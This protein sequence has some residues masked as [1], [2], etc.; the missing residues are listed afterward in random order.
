VNTDAPRRAAGPA[1]IGH[2]LGFVLAIDGCTR[3]CQHCPAFGSTGPALR[4]GLDTLT[5]RLESIAR[6]RRA[7][8]LPA[9]PTRTVHCWRISDPLDYWSRTRR[10]GVATAA[11]VA[12]LWRDHLHQALYV[13]T[14]GS[15]GHPAGR[16]ALATFA[17]TPVLVS[18]LKITIT[19]ADLDWGTSRYVAEL[20]E[21][22]RLLL[23]LWELPADR[24]EA[25][26]NAARLRLNVKTTADKL[27]EAHEITSAIL[28]AAGLTPH[29]VD[30]AIADPRRVAFKPIYDLGTT[31]GGPT[32]VVGA[33]DVTDVTGQRNKPTPETREGLQYGIRPDGRIFA[34]DMYAFTETD[35][36]DQASGLPLYWHDQ[37]AAVVTDA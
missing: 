4:V 18:Q 14:N 20:A 31:T 3:R 10:D 8:G 26:D 1:V 9:T 37:T 19:P 32:P 27:D 22:V 13:V 30:A 35:L 12:L 5:R 23:P 17:A 29:A 21:D 16:R 28:R 6:A 36:I 2:E 7:L 15:E 34:V 24:P 11:D 25:G 33:I